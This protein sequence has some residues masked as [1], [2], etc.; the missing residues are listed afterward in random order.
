[1]KIVG[2]KQRPRWA[3]PDVKAATVRAFRSVEMTH[4]ASSRTT[5][6]SDVLNCRRKTLAA[7]KSRLRERHR[8]RSNCFEPQNCEEGSG[9][10]VVRLLPDIA[11]RTDRNRFSLLASLPELPR[12]DLRPT[13]HAAT[14][15]SERAAF[16]GS[17][18]LAGI[19]VRSR[20]L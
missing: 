10:T 11:N 9:L 2:L 13:Q 14:A 8:N 16:Y 4:P 1:M 3:V 15:V 20:H 19:G 17:A 12:R 6:G 7:V 5:S 18:V